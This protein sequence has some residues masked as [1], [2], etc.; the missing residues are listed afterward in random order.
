MSRPDL[1]KRRRHERL[2]HTPS[3]IAPLPL[4][5]PLRHSVP[6]LRHQPRTDFFPR[7]RLPPSLDSR[8]PGQNPG[9][10]DR[11]AKGLEAI[12]KFYASDTAFLQPTGEGITGSAA[13]RTLFQTIKATFDNNLT[14]HSQNLETSGDL[15]YDSGATST[16]P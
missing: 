5:A 4:L 7:H 11:R 12:L 10:L 9:S 3:Q 6:G 13:L 14:L 16:K 1:I 15:A 2:F 8:N